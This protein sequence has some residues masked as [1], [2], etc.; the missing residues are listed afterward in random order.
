MPGSG[1]LILA[2]RITRTVENERAGGRGASEVAHFGHSEGLS[3][4]GH[5]WEGVSL[6][7]SFIGK[8]PMGLG[9]NYLK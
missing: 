3:D 9:Q 8:G 1:L 2:D 4:P 6:G 7:W 5:G